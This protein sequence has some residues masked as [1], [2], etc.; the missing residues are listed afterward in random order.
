MLGSFQGSALKDPPLMLRR[1]DGQVVQFPP[2]LYALAEELDGERDYDALRER[3]RDRA[4]VDIEADDVRQLVVQ[5]LAPM[6]VVQ[7]AATRN[8]ERADPLLALRFRVKVVPPGLV[9]ALTTVF[10]PFFL[11]PVILA[12]LVGFG[13]MDWWLLTLHGVAQSIRSSLY[14]PAVLLA[15][16]GFVILAAAF[17]EFGHATGCRYGGAEPGA[18]GFGIY[19]VWPAFYTDISDSIRLGR[20][21]RLRADLGGIYFHALFILGLVGAFFL[22]HFEPILLVALLLQIEI[23]RQMLPLLRFDGYFVVSD[24]VGIPDLFLRLKPIVLS[25][26]P[27]R[28]PDPKVSELKPWARVVVTIWVFVV[29]LGIGFYLVMIVLATPRIVGTA[30]ASFRS[31]LQAIGADFGAGRQLQGVLDVVQVVAL[32]LPVAGIVYTTI[33]LGRRAVRGWRKLRGRPAARAL[34]VGGIAVVLALV[35]WAWWP[36]QG[37][38]RPI[39]PSERWTVPSASQGFRGP[40]AANTESHH[41]TGSQVTAPLP[42]LSPTSA[43]PTTTPPPSA[44]ASPTPSLGTP[45]PTSTP[46]TTSPTAEP[47]ASPSP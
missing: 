17:H 27:G 29:L 18:M 10:R 1:P 28:A 47:T 14:D 26:I 2:L 30:W 23:V 25:L 12:A 24:L 32:S 41:G 8:A 36:Q 6:G 20:G 45:S 33:T 43:P 31:H 44:T 7:G 38:Y 39:Q 11:P 15:I 35:A 46:S 9:R 40:S 22:T 16:L 19:L 37:A 3:L 42:S 5:K 13:V 21:G 34:F 4:R